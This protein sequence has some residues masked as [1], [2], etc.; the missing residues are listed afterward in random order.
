MNKVFE[1]RDG[2]VFLEMDADGRVGLF[3]W[4]SDVGCGLDGLDAG[5]K[6]AVNAWCDPDESADEV[7]LKV[8]FRLS[9]A[10]N[11][12]F[13]IEGHEIEGGLIGPY[14]RPVHEA[15]RAELLEMVARIDAIKYRD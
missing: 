9:D 2:C 5:L 4:F 11:F 6:E 1:L 14:R 15:M 3:H 8:D 10:L 13:E 12:E 7:I